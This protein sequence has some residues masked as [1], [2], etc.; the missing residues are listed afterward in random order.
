MKLYKKRGDVVAFAFFHDE[1]RSIVLNTLETR[2]LLSRNAR[3]REVVIVEARGD[4]SVN[5]SA[6]ITSY[7]ITVEPAITAPDLAGPLPITALKSL[8]D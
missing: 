2:K 5:Q 4:S 3:K 1:T 8:T 6:P 7:C